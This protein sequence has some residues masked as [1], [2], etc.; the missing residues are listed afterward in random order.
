MREN[1]YDISQL[2]QD[3]MKQIFN[4]MVKVDHFQLGDLVLKWDA[5]FE[6]KAWEIQPFMAGTL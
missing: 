1:V 6:G 5:R 2:M 3:K 4:R